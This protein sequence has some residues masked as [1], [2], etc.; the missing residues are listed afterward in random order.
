MGWGWGEQGPITKP[1]DRLVRSQECQAR[2]PRLGSGTWALQRVQA[3]DSW[4]R[5]RRGLAGP[6]EEPPL[7]DTRSWIRVDLGLERKAQG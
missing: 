7:M 1:R 3:E 2:S 4:R 5:S 6:A